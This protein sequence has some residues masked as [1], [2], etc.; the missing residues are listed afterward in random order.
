LAAFSEPETQAI[1]D[2]YAGRN[3]QAMISYHNYSQLILYPWGYTAELTEQNDL[4]SQIAADMSGLIELVNGRIYVDEPASSLYLTNGDTTDWSFGVYG[5]PSFTIELPPEGWGYGGFF[6]AE[7]D[8]QPIFNEN[9]P[10]ALY[11]ID[12]SVQNFGSSLG[13]PERRRMIPEKWIIKPNIRGKQFKQDKQNIRDSHH[14]P[15]KRE[16]IKDSNV[17]Y[18]PPVQYSK[19]K[20]KPKTKTKNRKEIKEID[21]AHLNAY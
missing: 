19:S 21:K 15:V 3:F 16:K 18:N 7:E 4:H 5:I 9:L 20:A 17:D 8:I 6:N 11:L 1:R 14:K 10:A 2:F 13:I 12:W